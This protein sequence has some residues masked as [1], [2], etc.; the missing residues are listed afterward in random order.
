MLMGVYQLTT[1]TPGPLGPISH[2]EHSASLSQSSLLVSYDP[3]K[4]KK[5]SKTQWTRSG[6]C[7]TGRKWEKMSYGGV[8]LFRNEKNSEQSVF[9]EVVCGT[10]VEILDLNQVSL[11]PALH[12]WVNYSPLYFQLSVAWVPL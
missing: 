11:I 7:E 1:S 6:E 8:I 2:L 3:G 9:Q 10:M 5:M 12:S 4:K